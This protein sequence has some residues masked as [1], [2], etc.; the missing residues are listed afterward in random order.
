M[1]SGERW[2]SSGSGARKTAWT[3]RSWIG[4][5]RS[6]I[7]SQLLGPIAAALARKRPATVR[8]VVPAAAEA[9]LF[10][11]MELAHADRRPL[12]LQD[13]TLV[14]QAGRESGHVAPVG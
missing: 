13:V 5:S 3:S 1:A 7:G 9:L 10:R 12:S 14:M 2:G 11:P 6:W 8:V 4:T